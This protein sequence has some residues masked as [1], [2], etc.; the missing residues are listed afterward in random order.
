MSCL[1]ANI[2]PGYAQIESMLYYFDMLYT[3]SGQFM[4]NHPPP[5]K[6]NL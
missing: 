5:P 1:A 4:G 3:L 6:Y 2:I